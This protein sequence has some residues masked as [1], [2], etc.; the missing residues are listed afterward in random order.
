MFTLTK[1]M[2]KVCNPIISHFFWYEHHGAVRLSRWT[3]L[4]A[5]LRFLGSALPRTVIP[6][7][8]SLS[9]HHLLLWNHCLLRFSL[10]RSRLASR[11]QVKAPI[12]CTCTDAMVIGPEK[13][14]EQLWIRLRPLG[15][16]M[17]CFCQGIIEVKPSTGNVHVLGCI[18][19][20]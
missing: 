2:D 8:S 10:M 5:S 3:R 12:K 7:L 11:N 20:F 15:P 13:H 18:R 9:C 1:D 14:S 17:L 19:P 4:L 16:L 6:L